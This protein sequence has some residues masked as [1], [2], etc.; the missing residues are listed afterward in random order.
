MSAILELKKTQESCGVCDLSK[1]TKY[2]TVY[3]C[4]ALKRRINSIW[5]KR[6][7]NCPLKITVNNLRWIKHQSWRLNE[8]TAF[9]YECP[10]CGKITNDI[11]N[12]NG[13]IFNFCPH[14]GIKLLPP[15]EGE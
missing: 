4:N 1:K 14:C 3:I 15:K 7:P 8:L 6:H 12:Q 11:H 2:E 5:N 10:K 9:Y 13:D